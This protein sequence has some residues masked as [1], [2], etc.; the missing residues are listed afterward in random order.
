MIDLFRALVD[1]L[2]V[3]LLVGG[4]VAV[5]IG[6]RRMRRDPT[7]VGYYSARRLSWWGYVS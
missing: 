4:I 1:A 3:V 2:H 5:V 7:L 6:T